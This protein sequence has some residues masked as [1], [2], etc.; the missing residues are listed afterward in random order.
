MEP[1]QYSPEIWTVTYCM[2]R[3]Q[4][5]TFSEEGKQLVD[6]QAFGPF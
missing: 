4:I 2:Y 3:D 1:L 6:G 5:E